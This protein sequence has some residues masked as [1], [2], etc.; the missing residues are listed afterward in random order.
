[1][2]VVEP[3]SG[4]IG[5]R[6]PASRR[7]PSGSRSLLLCYVGRPAACAP[8]GFACAVSARAADDRLDGTGVKLLLKRDDLIHAD[9]PGNKWRKLK[10]NLLQPPMRGRSCC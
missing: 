3:R 7:P 5:V 4:L 10:Y 9:F 8:V 6:H 1:M 2:R